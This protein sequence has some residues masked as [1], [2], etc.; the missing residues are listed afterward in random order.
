MIAGIAV[1]LAVT[2]PANAFDPTST[3]SPVTGNSTWFS[4]VGGP[5]GGCGMPG[6][7]L[8]TQNYLALNVFN[9]PGDYTTYPRPLTGAN[10]SKMGMWDNGHNC[11]RW[12]QVTV[13]SNCNG[14]ND[15]APNQP[16]CRGGSGYVA[17]KYNGGVLDFIVADSCGDSNAW[18]RDDPYH[19]DLHQSSLN[20]F[21]KNGVTMTDMYPNNWNNRL[22]TWQFIQA[23]NYTGDIQIGW[24]NGAQVWWP[25]I[26]V[27][28]LANGIHSV[29]FLQNGVWTAATMDGDMG[30]AWIIGGT[31]AG[32]NN[33]EIRVRDVNDNLINNGQIYNLTIP[34]SCGSSCTP[35][36]TQ[37]TYTTTPG[38]GPTGTPPATTTPPVTTTPPATTTPPGTTPPATTTPPAGKSC[39][40]SYAI[41]NSYPNGFQT[42]VTVTAGSA[43]I[44]S[45]KVGWSFANGQTITQLW[46]GT[47]TVNGANVSVVNV[48]YNGSIAAGG[49]TTF[50][51]N[52][53]WNNTT[54]AIPTLTCSAS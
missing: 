9:T 38:G 14:T 20:S 46:N 34:S 45:W 44:S 25:A 36:Y 41:V 21:V 49:N 1:V 27:S 22:M 11:D 23:P 24:L 16:F 28:H 32:T 43:A 2:T 48:S 42:T 37:T 40:A 19:I 3:P 30:Q 5:Y 52:G 35:A 12:V 50:G 7:N 17:D 39:T 10:L 29:E 15:G 53:T 26:S 4:G 47:Q 51:F 33:F 13:N 31:T 6:A 54:N 18:C 8:E